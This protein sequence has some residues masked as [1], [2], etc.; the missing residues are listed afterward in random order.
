[1]TEH[2]IEE[3]TDTPPSP[4]LLPRRELDQETCVS[5]PRRAYRVLPGF[6]LHAQA[7]SR[8]LH[9]Q[10]LLDFN[11][12]GIWEARGCGEEELYEGGDRIL[13]MSCRE[14]SREYERTPSI[15]TGVVARQLGQ[16]L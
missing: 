8:R 3:D 4:V 10:I 9:R 5:K 14:G 2:R 16:G 11:G 6:P 15:S 13:D 1:M 12:L 7:P